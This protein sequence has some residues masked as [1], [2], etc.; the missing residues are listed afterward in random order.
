MQKEFFDFFIFDGYYRDGK[1]RI[2]ASME[3]NKIPVIHIVE[4]VP[5]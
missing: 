1:I 3:I 5:G 2:T 4:M